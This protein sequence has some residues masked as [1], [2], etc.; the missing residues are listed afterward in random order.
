LVD[1]R[2]E[3]RLLLEDVGGAG[4]VASFFSLKC[5]RSCRPFC[6]GWPVASARAQCEAEATTPRVC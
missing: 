4:L 5:M 2:I 6:S 3:T 1:K